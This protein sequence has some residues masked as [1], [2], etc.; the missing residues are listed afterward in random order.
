MTNQC[1]H[2]NTSFVYMRNIGGT[3]HLNIIVCDD[4]GKWRESTPEEKMEAG[5]INQPTGKGD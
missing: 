3:V 2:A 5:A 4:C 1:E